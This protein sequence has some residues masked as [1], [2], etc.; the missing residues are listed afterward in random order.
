MKTL[1]C[2]QHVFL[3]FLVT[4]PANALPNGLF[5]TTVNQLRN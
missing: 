5:T 4:Y 2:S 3:A 1:L